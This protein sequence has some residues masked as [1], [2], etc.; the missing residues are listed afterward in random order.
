MNVRALVLLLGVVLASPARAQQVIDLLRFPSNEEARA[1][2][3][4]MAEGPPVE[5]LTVPLHGRR[6]VKFPCDLTGTQDRGAWDRAILLNLTRADRIAF[7]FYV[8]DPSKLLGSYSLYFQSGDGWYHGHF[9]AEKGWQRIVLDKSQF[10]TEG[11][12]F[13]WSKIQRIRL[14]AWKLK[15]ATTFVAMDDLRAEASE[16]AVVLGDRTPTDAPEWE[17]VQASAQR[18]CQVLRAAGIDCGV[19]TDRDLE[20]GAL[21]GRKVALFGLNPHMSDRELD[22]V[23]KF[24]AGG[25]RIMAF[26]SVPTRLLRLLGLELK[27][28]KRQD[29]EGQ[30]SRIAFEKDRVSGMPKQVEQSSWNINVV[31]P[32]SANTRVIGEWQDRDGRSTGLPAVTL[33]AQ[34][35]YMSHVLLLDD[36]PGKIRMMRA[37]LAHFKPDLWSK[38]TNAALESADQVGEFTDFAA[39]KAFIRGSSREEARRRLATAEKLRNAARALAAKGSF[40]EAIDTALSAHQD[41]VA[42]YCAAFTPKAGEIRAVWC[43]AATGVPGRSWEET[44]S[45]LAKAGF[46][47]IVPNMLWAGRAYYPS[48]VLPVDPSVATGGDQIAICLAAAK[49]HG[50]QVHVW[51]V[52]WNLQNA[53]SEFLARMRSQGRTQKAP[54]GSDIDWLCPTHPDNFTLE[55]DSMVEVARNYAVDGLHFDY[56]RYPGTNGCYCSGCRERF[57]SQFGLK[58]ENWPADVLRGPL[59]EKYLAF[60]RSHI[61]NLVRAVSQEARKIRPGIQISAAVFSDWPYCRDSIGQDWANWVKE[62]LLDF[63]CPMNYTNSAGTIGSLVQNQVAAIEGAKPLVSGIGVTSSQSGLSP[64]QVAR[65]IAAVRRSGAKGFILFNLDRSLLDDVLPLLRSGPT[66]SK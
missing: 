59:R 47:R 22:Q 19:L 42:A 51:K 8:D 17:S 29:F 21:V 2:W 11:V 5:A 33:S 41:L 18:V 43:H 37:I 27:E 53:P 25:G 64:D 10:T 23:E 13:G 46:Q 50:L 40:S 20:E 54:D 16:I 62:G 57:E 1:A 12:P 28:W 48:K 14:S 3:Q 9:N 15:A 52:N 31:Q 26:Y 56:I 34:G 38:S 7:W 60:R 30:L 49:K 32:T 35:A 36:L 24:V 44:I 66:A 55:R 39:A 6:G 45:E 65:Q 63:V 58:V 61:T 4:P